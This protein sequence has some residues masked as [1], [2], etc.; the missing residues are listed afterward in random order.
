M[1]DGRWVGQEFAVY[2]VY[3]RSLG[4]MV[5]AV[6]ID[7]WLSLELIPTTGLMNVIHGCSREIRAQSR[8]D[9]L[10]VLFG[11]LLAWMLAK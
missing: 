1:G 5:S 7:R 3:S 11:N 6:L 4:E 8:C 10:G 2:S 9:K